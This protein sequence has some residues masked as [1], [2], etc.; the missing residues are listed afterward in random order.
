MDMCDG[1]FFGVNYRV[2]CRFQLTAQRYSLE[3]GI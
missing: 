3:V 1:N 2:R